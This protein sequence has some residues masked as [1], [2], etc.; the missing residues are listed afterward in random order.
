[1]GESELVIKYR[2][3]G[4]RAVE[5]LGGRTAMSCSNGLKGSPNWNS[6]ISNTSRSEKKGE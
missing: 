3:C 1:M 5:V 2:R 6:G 4:G